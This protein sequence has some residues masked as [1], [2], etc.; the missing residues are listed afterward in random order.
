MDIAH[1]SILPM[2]INESGRDDE[3]VEEIIFCVGIS[4]GADYH[5][6]MPAGLSLIRRLRD[7]T[8]YH[9]CYAQAKK[10]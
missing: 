4:G 5:N 7:G 1:E 9:M 2:R 6:D 10:G 3:P 8:E